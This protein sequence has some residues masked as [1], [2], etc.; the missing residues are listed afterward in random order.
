KLKVGVDIPS[1]DEVRRIIQAAPDKW[2]RGL[3]VLTFAGLRASEVRGLRWHDVD[4]KRG[5]L[6]VR[7][8]ADRYKEFGKP[9]SKTNE[10]TIP[11]GP[12]VLNTLKAWKLA[13]PKSE[14]DLVFPSTEG[15]VIRLENI[16][17]R[18]LI[19]AQKAAG[20]VTNNG[21]AKYTG[22]HALRHF[23]AS[24]CINRRA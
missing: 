17:R 23:Y 8:R 16:I 1:G 6:H 9:K 20:V 14:H 12:H 18:G 5:Q 15:T 7:Q 13:C 10:R 24:W 3:L 19:P 21:K 22:L 11:L 2:R 4:T